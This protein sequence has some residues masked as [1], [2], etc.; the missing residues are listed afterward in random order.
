MFLQLLDGPQCRFN[1]KITS[2]VPG[3]FNGDAF[4]DVLVTLENSK[5]VLN[6]YIITGN[7]INL[8]CPQFDEWVIQDMQGE[9]LALDFNHDMIID[10]FGLNKDGKRT[11]WKFTNRTNHTNPPQEIEMKGRFG[12][13]GDLKI[14]H[15]HAIVDLNN[16]FLADLVVTCENGFEIWDGVSLNTSE[17]GFQFNT[18]VKIDE[19]VKIFGQAIF[20]DIELQGRLDQVV[21]VC[22]DT[23]CSNSTLLVSRGNHFVMLHIIFKGLS[24]DHWGFAVPDPDDM[25]GNTIPLRVGDYNL[26]GYPD[27][28][29]TLQKDGGGKQTF[30]M[31]NVKCERYCMGLSRTFEIKWNGLAPAG[32]GNIMGSFYDFYQDGILDVILTEKVGNQYRPRAFRNTLDYDANFVKVIVLTGLTNIKPP[33]TRTPLGRTKNYYGT[34]LPGPLIEY[35]TTNQDGTPLHGASPQLSQSAYMSLQ[36][37]Y[38]VFGLGRTPNFVDSLTVGLVSKQKTW[39]QLIPNSQ[40]IVVP[41]P[42][43]RPDLWKAQLFVTPS[44]L[45][46]NSVIALGGVIL[47][48]L[49]IILFLHFKEKRADRLE[50]QQQAHRFHF[51]AM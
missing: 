39:P 9:P 49:L 27:I 37:P 23:S 8:S 40:M 26:D 13:V 47:A 4:M 19:Q 10:L 46:L 31:E 7:G 2:V 5:N 16:D 20:M 15:S 45:I 42:L 3:D 1:N 18:T 24:N 28:L 43:N 29:V 38:T 11:F 35:R 32:M 44:K 6:A 12:N 50:K 36:L 30:L 48:I 17:F 33:S 22:F 21:P 14:P 51:D 34:N 41:S 25:Y